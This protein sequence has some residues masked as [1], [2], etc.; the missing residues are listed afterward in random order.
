MGEPIDVSSETI[1][2]FI[3]RALRGPLNTPVLVR[4]FASFRRRFGG[5]WHRSSLGPAVRQFFEHGGRQ[6][7]IVRV[8]NSARGAMICLPAKGGFLILRALEPGSTENIRAAVDYDGINEADDRRFNLAIQR[9]EP[10]TGFVIDQEIYH[11]VHCDE[12]GAS[13]IGD[14][15]LSSSLVRAQ[16]PLPPG[17]P[18]E[19]RNS[20]P[21]Y[22]STYIGHAQQGTDG[23]ALSDYD[24]IGSAL[25]GTG[26]FALNQIEHFDL[27]YMPPPGRRLDLGPPAVLAAELYCRKRGAMLILDPPES[28]TTAHEA[29]IGVRRSGFSSPN[30]ISYFPRMYSRYDEDAIPRATGGAIAGLLCKLDSADGPWQDLDQRNF[31]FSRNLVPANKVSIDEARLLVKEGLNVIAGNTAGRATLCGSVT[32]GRG[33]QMER[34]FTSLT[35]RRLCLS[36]TNAIDSATRWAVFEPDVS[37]VASRIQSQ[38]HAYMCY[39]ADAG[40]FVDDAFMVQCNAGLHS[41]PVDPHRG[42]TILLGFHPVGSDEPVSLTLHQTV[43]GCRV[44]TTAFAPS[45]AEVA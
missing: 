28:W 16:L 9:L 37:R 21:V 42:I 44:A 33:T 38:V 39:L 20:G 8:A 36:I 18:I 40:A 3:G 43:A 6:L 27:L 14:A 2:A 22:E 30:I 5:Y 29:T 17:R 19:T 31:G 12:E 13:S 26:L 24:L 7:Y 10:D 32:L 25:T 11:R 4:N 41:Y 1:A 34:S 45:N 23:V 15:L 35:V